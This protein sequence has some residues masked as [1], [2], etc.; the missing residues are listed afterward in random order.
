[1]G[2]ELT[3]AAAIAPVRYQQLHV[4]PNSDP[5][6]HGEHSQSTRGP[7]TDPS[8][9]RGTRLHPVEFSRSEQ[10]AFDWFACE[11]RAPVR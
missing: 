2:L 5:T 11:L 4:T 3:M 8:I 6:L 7:S 1:V 9:L 10:S